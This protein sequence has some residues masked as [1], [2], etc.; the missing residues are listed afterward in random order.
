[1]DFQTAKKISV[2]E[3]N[4]KSITEKS[5][6]A[7]LWKAG[8]QN[9]VPT[10]IDTDGS[11][12]NGCG[13]KN[14][15][16]IRSGGALG[17]WEKAACTGNIAVRAGDVL[18]FKG[19]NWGIASVENCIHYAAEGFVSLGSFTPQPA[20]YGICTSHNAM[21]TEENGVYIHTVPNVAEIRY[22]RLSL[23]GSGSHGAELVVT[24]NEE[25][26]E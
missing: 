20:H 1:M 16:R 13:Y 12:F 2:P 3:G 19:G 22:V 11:I 7:L 8:Y 4:V 9:L 6:G 5:S 18:R 26:T 21:V 25:I 15:Y 24:V 17:E 14:G 23:Y 10:S